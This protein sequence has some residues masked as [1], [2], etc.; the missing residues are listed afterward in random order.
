MDLKAAPIILELSPTG[1]DNLP[2][3]V[4]V[5]QLGFQELARTDPDGGQRVCAFLNKRK[6]VKQPHDS[7]DSLDELN[8]DSISS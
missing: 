1:K 7:R 4:Q 2:R 3:V 8:R 6:A 5:G